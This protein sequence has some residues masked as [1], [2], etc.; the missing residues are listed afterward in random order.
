MP[1]D[2]AGSPELALARHIRRLNIK[3]TNAYAQVDADA[4][5]RVLSTCFGF[6]GALR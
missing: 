6:T 2:R 1:P 5:S 3:N 4:D